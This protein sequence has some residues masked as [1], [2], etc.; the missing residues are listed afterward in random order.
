MRHRL[1]RTD[2]ASLLVDTDL[3][4]CL[5]DT[6]LLEGWRPRGT[7]FPDPEL[8]RESTHEIRWEALAYFLPCG[9]SIEGEDAREL[10]RCCDQ[11]LTRVSDTEIPLQARVFGAQNTLSLL[12]RAAARED[13]PRDHVEA[14]FELLS[15]PPKRQALELIRFLRLGHVVIRPERRPV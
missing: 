9:Q 3:W 8:C 1:R 12:R 11:A 15:G 6:A 10:A 5:L 14:A 13:I 7:R 2:G 4:L